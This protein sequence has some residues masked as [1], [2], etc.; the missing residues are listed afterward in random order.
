MPSAPE[1]RFAQSKKG[2]IIRSM[3]SVRKGLAALSLAVLAALPMIAAADTAAGKPTIEISKTAEN[4][5]LQ[6]SDYIS[7]V[8]LSIPSEEERL[9]TDVVF[10]LDKSSFSDTAPTALQL[11]S[12]LERPCE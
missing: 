7:D 3:R 8:K 5:V 9:T 2:E 1:D 6:G 4:L 11:L 10:I 12:T